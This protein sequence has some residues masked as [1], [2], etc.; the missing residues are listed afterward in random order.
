MDALDFIARK[1]FGKPLVPGAGLLDHSDAYMAAYKKSYPD[2]AVAQCWPHIARKCTKGEYFPK[3][4][5]HFNEA[6]KHITAIHFALTPEMARLLADEA[7]ELWDAWKGKKYMNK[8]W[9]SYCSGQWL[10][11]SVG[12]LNTMFATPNQ[13]TQEA[14]HRQLK[15]NRIPGLMNGS[16]E[17]VFA[18]AIPQLVTLDGV[19]VPSELCYEVP[20]MYREALVKADWFVSHK[21]THIHPFRDTNGDIAYYVLKRHNAGKYKRISARLIEMFEAAL[22]G[23]KDRRIKDYDHLKDVCQAIHYVVAE[24]EE[25]AVPSC[26]GN[27]AGLSCFCK[28]YAAN[29]YCSAII[30][31]NTV[32]KKYDVRRGLGLIAGTKGK[33]KH[34]GNR[35]YIPK[36]LERLQCVAPD[37]SEEEDSSDEE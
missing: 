4:W 1:Y 24:E 11:W 15:D 6:M 26:E 23:E 36:A 9:N 25:G 22:R 18:H 29:G 16:T 31:V 17:T 13:N 35:M 2:T 20:A 8:F 21:D 30:A 7:G 12:H 19:L 10:N 5:D 28:G 34:G 33:A 27:P 32:L 37:S 3:N 14:W